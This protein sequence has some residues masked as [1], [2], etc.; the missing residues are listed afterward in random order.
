MGTIRLFAAIGAAVL[1]AAGAV[2]R[3]VIAPAVVKLPANLDT[4]VRLSGTASMVDQNALRSGNLAGVVRDAVPV[5]VTNRV[6]VVST[7]GDTAIITSQSTVA[8][9]DNAALQ[10]LTHTWAVDRKTFYPAQAPP[11]SA[12]EPHD[13]LVLGF[14]LPPRPQDYPWWD[15]ITQTTVTARYQSTETYH[16]RQVYVYAIHADG[17]VKD[18]GVVKSLPVKQQWLGLN[19]TSD[20]T[21][22]VDTATSFPLNV[23]QTTRMTVTLAG[24]GLPLTVFS[25]SARYAPQAATVMRQSAQTTE[26]WLDLL[27]TVAPL[28]L[29]GLGLL[30]LPWAFRLR[31]V[32]R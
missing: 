25:L 6:R 3:F 18:P 1:I 12:V 11:G 5:T 14:P 8:G 28:A 7:R 24:F 23:D 27:N 31:R 32:G 4:T 16:G 20:T 22:W 17:P 30:L 26:R 21:F 29:V 10:T 13:G 2:L 15:P 9:R 19:S